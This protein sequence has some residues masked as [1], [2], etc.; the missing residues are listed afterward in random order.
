MRAENEAHL[1]RV[2]TDFLRRVDTKYRRGQDE[3]GGRL[4]EYPR[5]QLLEELM[6]EAVNVMGLLAKGAAVAE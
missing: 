3:H 2:K 5:R 6:A 1:E 4:W